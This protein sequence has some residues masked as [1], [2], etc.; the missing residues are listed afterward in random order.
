MAD[1]DDYYVLLGVGRDADEKSLKAA[2][3]K[4]AV[5]FHPDKNPGNATAESKFKE[6]NEAYSILGDPDK[7]AAYD[8]YGKAAFQNGGGGGQGF[9]GFGS[10]FTDI[11]EDLFGDF[12]GGGR[13]QRGGGRNRAAR[14]SDMR[15]NLELSLEEAFKGKAATLTVPTTMSCDGCNGSGAASGSQPKQCPTCGG[16]GKVRASQGFFVVERPCNG[17]GGAGQIIA[18]PCRKCRGAGR[19]ERERTLQV[20]IP[21]G[22]DEGTRIRLSGE[23]EAGARG[24]PSGDLYVFIS[25]KAH[26]IFQ[27]DGT[28]LFCVA[29]LPVTTAALGG[30]I[31]VPSLDG[32]RTKVKIPAGS[33]TGRQ[34]RLRGKG[35]PPLSGSGH[36]DLIIQVTLETPVHLTRKQRELLEA[37]RDAETDE[38]APESTGFFARLKEWW[39][40]ES[41]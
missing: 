7:R 22:V 32:Q 14:G 5:Q 26:P 18:D 15:Y 39:D 24:G 16:A 40:S 37:F 21:A 8:R 31:D 2:F 20:T 19:V 4:K 25:L 1:A 3:R 13:G 28:T 11:F 6:I 12:M 9:E 29:P 36:G 38:N 33:Q 17:C 10:A 23:G 27:R 30:E 34:F 41:A 35:M